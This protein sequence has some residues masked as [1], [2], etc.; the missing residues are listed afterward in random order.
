MPAQFDAFGIQFLYPENWKTVQ[1]EE[2]E[3]DQG[4]TFDLPSGGFVSIEQTRSVS[5]EELIGRIVDAISEEYD[6][7]EQER[8][9]LDVLPEEMAATDF[10]FYYLDL[11][12]VSRVVV[13][14]AMDVPGDDTM[15]VIQI[16]AESRDFDENEV[17]FAAILK[18]ILD[19]R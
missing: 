5:E 1:R 11:L 14:P 2:G 19:A 13:V 18:Q 4:V 16:Q 3:G 8:V 10:R 17:V 7:L 12:I 6:E 9:H 15:L